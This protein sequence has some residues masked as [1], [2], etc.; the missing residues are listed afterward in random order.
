V[1]RHHSAISGLVAAGRLR[2]EQGSGAKVTQAPDLAKDGG[3]PEAL[4]VT[5]Q[6]EGGEVLGEGIEAVVRSAVIDWNALGTGKVYASV[7]AVIAERVTEH[8]AA[9]LSQARTK[10]DA[11]RDELGRDWHRRCNEIIAERDQARADGAAEERERIARYAL[12]Q[13]SLTEDRA[14]GFALDRTPRG[15]QDYGLLAGAGRAFRQV[16]RFTGWKSS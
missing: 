11:E 4:A 9:L 15:R 1:A 7:S 14:D 5:G 6:G 8:V 12:T 13:A 2:R 16:A 10:A 3:Y